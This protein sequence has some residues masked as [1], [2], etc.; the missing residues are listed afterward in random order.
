MKK[1]YLGVSVMMAL[2]LVA[3][4]GAGTALA[5]PQVDKDSKKCIACHE[6][7]GMAPKMIEQWEKSKHAENGVGCLSCHGA[8][9][10]D[11]DAFAHNGYTVGLY[12]TPKDCS[13]CHA[14]EV[15][16]HTKSKHAYPFWLYAPADRAIFEPIVGTK[17]GCESCHNISNLWPDGSVGECDAC[18]PKHSFSVEVAR[19][20]Q[21]CGEC[22]LG[23]DHPHIEI[24][25]ESKHGNIYAAQGDKWDLSYNSEDHKNVPIEA[26]VCTTCH[27]DAVGEV[28]STHN[29]SERLAWESQAP[30]SYRTVWF[31]EELGSWE[32]KSD[33]M[34]TVCANCHAPTFIGD[35][36]LAFDLVNLQYNEIRR[37]FLK[38]T[39]LYTEKGLIKPLKETFNDGTER[40]QSALV[41]N[42]GWYTAASELMYN[43][44]H[45]EGRR[46]RHGSAMGGA[47]Y[48]QWHGIWELQHDLQEMIGWG[49]EHGVEEAK[50]IAESDSPARFFTY[51]L[52][53]Y[54]GGAYSVAT[55]EQ[56]AVATVQQYIPDYWEKV[57]ANVEQAFTQG[58]LSK[59]AWERWM[60]RYDNKDHYDGTKYGDHPIYAPYEKR[61]AREL[62]L[63]DPNSPLSRAIKVGLP[64]PSPA[65]EKIK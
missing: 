25:N 5:A 58:L 15:T 8:E 56:Q 18:H 22:H 46:F 24:Y 63:K 47:D 19:T 52:Y 62:N 41:I 53:D 59:A 29:V 26:P 37:E 14:E 31:E 40:N 20:P 21:T 48:V 55:R 9:E 51:K 54:P 34:Q 6:A 65:E 44:W 1:W 4:V 38:W 7:A 3:L 10:G 12:P 23:P 45:H 11:F 61:K 39:K 57:K 2:A 17:Q 16:E 27:M 43:G 13:A 28:K 32:E 33:R 30:W 64:S 42:A 49:A 36:F 35:H 50:K 60:E